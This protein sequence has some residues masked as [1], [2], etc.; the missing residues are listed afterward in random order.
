MFKRA[1]CSWNKVPEAEVTPNKIREFWEPGAP[2]SLFLYRYSSSCWRRVPASLTALQGTTEMQYGNTAAWEIHEL[3]KSGKIY[4][5]CTKHL[6]CQNR[7]YLRGGLIMSLVHSSCSSTPCSNCNLCTGLGPA[8]FI[9]LL[10]EPTCLV[11]SAFKQTLLWLCQRILLSYILALHWHC[12]F[13]TFSLLLEFMQASLGTSISLMKI[14]SCQTP[15]QFLYLFVCYVIVAKAKSNVS[16]HLTS[17]PAM[18]G[19]VVASRRLCYVIA[20]TE[21]TE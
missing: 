5:N 21:Q 11:L 17:I 16:A 1:T 2:N 10:Q 9:F 18:Q 20:Y 13:W 19:L 6:L 7:I 12:D 14:P 15:D 8:H 3:F 4:S